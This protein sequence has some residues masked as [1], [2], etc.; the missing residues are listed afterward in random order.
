[1]QN[2]HKQLGGVKWIIH[3]LKPVKSG[4]TFNFTLL[5][6]PMNPKPEKQ[7]ILAQLPQVDKLLQQ[8]AILQLTKRYPR[9]FVIDIIREQL[10]SLRN[11]LL[12]S[13]TDKDSKID[14]DE[15]IAHITANV[16]KTLQNSLRRAINASGIVLHTG[17]GR[18]P[19]SADVKKNVLDIVENFS[20]LEIELESGKRGKREQHV[21]K[22]I[23]QLT[24]A[25]SALVVNYNA[26][27][28]FLV[29]NTLSAGKESIVSRGEL[30][31]IGG[32][33]RLPEIMK[34]SGAL[35]VDIGT[36]NHTYQADYEEFVNCC[37]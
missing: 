2:K 15:L 13:T 3:F 25:E 18:A 4:L 26:A 29:L 37:R 17:L 20:T 9:D 11:Q 23:C 12:L 1:M 19:L 30:I 31:T 27:A 34:K 21:E 5:Y 6:Q 7:K 10:N 28:T 32:S 14:L 24:G 22:L 35:M 16:T 8:S 36:T 33:F